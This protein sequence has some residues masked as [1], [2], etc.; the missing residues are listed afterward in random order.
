MKKYLLLLLSI[1]LVFTFVACDKEETSEEYATMAAVQGNLDAMNEEDIDAYMSF[2]NVDA[3]LYDATEQQLIAMFDL[4][5]IRVKAT[6]MEVIDVEGDT[7]QVR[8]VQETTNENEQEFPGNKS[9][10]VHTLIKVD[11]AWKIQ[12]SVIES[13]E[14]LK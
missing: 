7:A 5:D 3:S 12:S 11:G 4:Y 13:T 9:T 1:L 8:V 10:A 6:D 14:E 2:V